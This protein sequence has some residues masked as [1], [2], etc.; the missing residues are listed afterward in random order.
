MAIPRILPRR[1][2]RSCASAIGRALLRRPTRP[3][4]PSAENAIAR[5]QEASMPGSA[6]TAASKTPEA[7]SAPMQRHAHLPRPWPLRPRTVRPT[8]DGRPR[9]PS[10][11]P[12]RSRPDRPKRDD[13]PARLQGSRA[14]FSPLAPSPA[15]NRS[16]VRPPSSVEGSVGL[17]HDLGC[18]TSQ[19][20]R[21]I[22][23]N[24]W[25]VLA[26]AFPDPGPDLGRSARTDA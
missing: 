3:S 5:T 14:R 20:E 11:R 16:F 10:R 8:W 1:S 25:L 13:D 17:Q 4:R 6:T 22:R 12:S 2:R 26:R 18:G 7:R 21:L 23:A 15:S 19:L 9:R 24:A